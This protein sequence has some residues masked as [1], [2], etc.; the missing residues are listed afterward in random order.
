LY[1]LDRAL[2]Y[3]LR[4]VVLGY[5]GARSCKGLYRIRALD[6]PSKCPVQREE[7]LFYNAQIGKHNGS[8]SHGITIQE[9]PVSSAI[10]SPRQRDVIAHDGKIHVKGRAYSGG[11]RWPERV[12]VSPDGGFTRYVVPQE[13]L[14]KKHKR[15]W[16]LWRIELPLVAEAWVEICCRCW[17]NALNTQPANVRGVLNWSAHLTNSQHCVSIYSVNKQNEATREGLRNLQLQDKALVPITL[18]AKLRGPQAVESGF[19]DPRDPED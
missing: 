2:I 7:Y 10:L 12:E 4:A 18:P 16:R 6:A 8:L 19:E 3:P 13:G 5:I 15:A 9:M 1:V 17:D 11:A 14:S